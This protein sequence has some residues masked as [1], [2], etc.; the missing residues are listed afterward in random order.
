MPSAI[1]RTSELGEAGAFF[2][3][4]IDGTPVL[5]ARDAQA[6][7]RAFVNI[8]R[9][10][11]ARLVHERQGVTKSFTCILH[12][13]TYDATGIMGGAVLARL[14]RDN[15]MLAVMQTTNALTPLPCELRHGFVWVMP[16]P[17]DE[18]DVAAFLGPLDAVLAARSVEQWMI[19]ERTEMA[20]ESKDIAPAPTTFEL[21]EDSLTVYGFRRRRAESDF[22]EDQPGEDVTTLERLVLA[23]PA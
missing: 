1:C 7:V 17:R 19:R 18:I 22:G 11:G 10:Q 5:V 3:A 20:L 6:K 15:P 4:D 8:C 12:G 2:T 23:R 9:H 21:R 16:K 13:W 14:A